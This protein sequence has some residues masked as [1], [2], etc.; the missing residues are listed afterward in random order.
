MSYLTFIIYLQLQNNIYLFKKKGNFTM[1]NNE[2]LKALLADAEHALRYALSVFTLAEKY[3]AEEAKEE[4]EKKIVS[5][6]PAKEA[7]AAPY[8]PDA[9]MYDYIFNM[10]P[11]CGKCPGGEC[12]QCM[13]KE[14][15]PYLPK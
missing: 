11:Y 6:P 5:A 7:E 2:Q 9:Y 14:Y 10:P 15:S 1:K 3:F 8:D 12:E 13:N 4:T